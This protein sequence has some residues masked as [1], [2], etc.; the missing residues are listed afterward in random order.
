M[1]V[2]RIRVQTQPSN[3]W[4]QW[5]PASLWYEWNVINFSSEGIAHGCTSYGASMAERE[6]DRERGERIVDVTM[7]FNACMNKVTVWEVCLQTP[8]S[9]PTIFIQLQT[10]SRAHPS[11]SYC[12][13]QILLKYAFRFFS[14]TFSSY[15]Y[16]WLNALF[17]L[18]QNTDREDTGIG[19]S[20]AAWI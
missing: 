12:I 13:S 3:L 9:V 11:S 19:C 15:V 8:A 14:L 18:P 5:G 17:Y 6:R 1:H 4:Q 20:V 7:R 16:S 2:L 10:A